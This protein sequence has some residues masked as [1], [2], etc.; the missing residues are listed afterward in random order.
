MIS[1]QYT[2]CGVD[3]MSSLVAPTLFANPCALIDGPGIVD[4]ESGKTIFSYAHPIFGAPFS[5]V[6]DG[7]APGKF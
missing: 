5:L 7:A 3:V 2:R 4:I 1:F 6:G